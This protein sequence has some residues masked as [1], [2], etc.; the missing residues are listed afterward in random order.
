MVNHG[1]DRADRSN[2]VGI[3]A[4]IT[5]NARAERRLPPWGHAAGLRKC[6][7]GVYSIRSADKAHR[8]DNALLT[9]LLVPLV[10]RART[11][12]C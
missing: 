11:R 1:V 10:E 9:A 8:I 4:S 5:G 7:Y 12:A 3:L 2:S 6:P